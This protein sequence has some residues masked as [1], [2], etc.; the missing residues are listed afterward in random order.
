MVR[1]MLTVDG[2]PSD[3]DEAR[4]FDDWEDWLK[5]HQKEWHDLEEHKAFRWDFPPP[6]AEIV[7][8]RE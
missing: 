8:S 2:E 1:A 5:A 6:N 7:D 3:I 4:T